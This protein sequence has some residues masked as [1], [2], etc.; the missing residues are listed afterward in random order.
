MLVSML[1]EIIDSYR[2]IVELSSALLTP[3][4]AVIGAVIAVFQYKLARSR[5]RLALYDKRYPVFLSVRDYILFA[6]QF[7]QMTREGITK[8]VRNSIDFGFLF[9]DEI[10]DYLEEL[11]KKGEGLKILGD[12][13]EKRLDDKDRDET[14]TQMKKITDWFWNQIEESKRLFGAYLRIDKK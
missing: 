4:I 3:M 6:V 11:N 2:Q 1:T 10:R 14:L 9:G 5:W 7:G 8:L 13:L 12:R